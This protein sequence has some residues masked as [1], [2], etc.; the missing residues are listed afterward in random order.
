MR[1]VTPNQE[2]VLTGRGVKSW[3]Y[4]DVL[5]DEHLYMTNGKEREI[6]GAMYLK[7]IMGDIQESQDRAVIKVFNPDGKYTMPAINGDFYR[8]PVK[9]MVAPGDNTDWLQLLEPDYVEHDYYEQPLVAVDPI[10]SF[11]GHIS[12]VEE[13]SDYITIIASR[14]VARRFPRGRIISPFANYQAQDGAVINFGSKVIRIESRLKRGT[15]S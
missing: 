5:L 1:I 7:G 6:G 14:G 12:A 3:V 8:N 10:L 13:V 11:S 9:I 4:V 2:R 15:V